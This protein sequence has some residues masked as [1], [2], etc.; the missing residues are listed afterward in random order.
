MLL[1]YIL[2]AVTI[3]SAGSV[4][5]A[6]M[7]MLL[8]DNLLQK[9]STL[10]VSLAGGTLL[11]AVFLGMLPKAAELMDIDRV[12]MITLSGIVVFFVL[13]KIILWHSC[14]NK[15]CERHQ[16]ASAQLIL[17]G[18]A[19]H[20]FIDGVVITSAFFASPAFGMLV[21]L[22][23]FAHEIPQE[24]ADFGILLKHGY[25]KKKALTYNMISGLMAI[26]AGLLSY[27]ALESVN[28]LVPWLLAFSAA[29]FA[30]IALADLVPQM[31]T[32]TNIKDAMVQLILILTGISIIYII[33]L[34]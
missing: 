15:K 21:T 33:K 16:N 14:F 17:V 23:V 5:L 8:P 18:D 19:F 25:S 9:V 29:S 30:Y 34:I 4:G 3:G 22:S 31:H 27:F 26:P 12:L 32:K 6:G 20:N 1:I 24:L 2:I 11:G 28:N 10:F 7:L 13:E